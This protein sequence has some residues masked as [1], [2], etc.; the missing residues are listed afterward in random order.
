MSD[1]TREDIRFMRR[2]LRLA[3]KGLRGCAPNP[4][5]GCVI[6]NRGQVAG[7]GFHARAGEPHAEIMALGQAG[8]KARGGTA[9]VTLEP[10]SHHGRTP[11][12]APALVEAGLSRV[13]VGAGDPNPRVSGGGLDMLKQAGI[14][15]EMGVCEAQARRINRGFFSRFERGRPWLTL[16]L[17]ASLDGRSALANG[18]SQWI[19]GPVSRAAV[20][21][22]RARAGAVMTGVGTVL[23]DDPLLNAR[24]PG[25]RRQPLRVVLDSALSLSPQAR[26]LEDGNGGAV[27]VFCARGAEAGR[28]ELLVAAG[29]AVHE[30]E[31]GDDGRP[32]PA[33]V[34]ATLAELE[35]N[36]VYVECGPRL[37]G[38]LIDSGLVDE[39]ELFQGPH[40]FGSDALGIAE[41][42]PRTRI[43]DPPIWWIVRAQRCGRD[44]RIRMQME[45]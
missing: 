17:A 19:T 6:V 1:V 16:K 45:K 28:R 5:V 8:E 35:V 40:L 30:I 22:A 26:L 11:P 20:H 36:E 14:R 21:R 32:L 7:E 38:A 25:Q 10:C 29:A 4:A 9:Y 44:V 3:V 42:P 18:T 24:L 27:H 39:L 34:L 13:V 31:A 23:A 33:S 12:C 41:L 37:A 43:P 15:V 2:A